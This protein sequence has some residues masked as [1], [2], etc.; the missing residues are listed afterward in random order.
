MVKPI[1]VPRNC[2]ARLLKINSFN[3]QLIAY[4]QIMTYYALRVEKNWVEHDGSL[5]FQLL[6]YNLINSM[7]VEDDEDFDD[8]IDASDFR[9]TIVRDWN[10][11][12]LG[13]REG[14]QKAIVA[15][16]IPSKAKAKICA[17]KK[18][19]AALK[20]KLQ[21]AN[22]SDSN[23]EEDTDSVSTCQGKA[24]ASRHMSEKDD[25]DHPVDKEESR[26][27]KKP[28]KQK[29]KL[30]KRTRDAN[31]DNAPYLLTPLQSESQ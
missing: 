7:K 6:Y 15:L 29:S 26:I 12:M 28:S 16:E 9:T 27:V 18:K 5:D 11:N 19:K 24:V 2:V 31:N 8:L 10:K 22:G 20:A 30:M 25:E 3:A 4:F 23:E 17:E 13:A 14:L 21:A 1:K